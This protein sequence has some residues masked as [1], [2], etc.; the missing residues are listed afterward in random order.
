VVRTLVEESP[1]EGHL[2]CRTAGNVIVDVPGQEDMLG[3]FA[4]VEITSA[5]NWTLSGRIL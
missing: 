1:D 5:R 2:S 3:R 4:D